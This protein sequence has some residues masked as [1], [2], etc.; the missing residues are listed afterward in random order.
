MPIAKSHKISFSTLLAALRE[1]GD[2]FICHSAEGVIYDAANAAESPK[3]TYDEHGRIMPA[4]AIIYNSHNSSQWPRVDTKQT[5]DELRRIMPDHI[6]ELSYEKVIAQT[7]NNWVINM[8]EVVK[9]ELDLGTLRG[10]RIEFLKWAIDK[11]GD[12]EITF[13]VERAEDV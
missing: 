8:P 13:H 9:K 5:Y 12:Q 1:H 11:F 6:R 4:E 10:F 7:L 3:L 2:N